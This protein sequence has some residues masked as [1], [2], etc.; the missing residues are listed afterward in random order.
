MTL[1]LHETLRAVGQGLMAGTALADPLCLVAIYLGPDVLA[2]ILIAA[3]PILITVA[4][5][6]KRRDQ[7]KV[8]DWT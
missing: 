6:L 2:V 3:G 5:A 1:P 7:R 8:K 4:N